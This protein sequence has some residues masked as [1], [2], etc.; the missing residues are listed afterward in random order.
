MSTL[1]ITIGE[2]IDGILERWG[3]ILNSALKGGGVTPYFGVGF[4]TMAQFGAA[5]TPKRWELVE[6]L[7]TTGPLTMDALAKRLH[8]HHRNV[9]KDVTALMEW[10]VIEKDEDDKLFVPWDEIAVR[11]P[12]LKQ[13][14]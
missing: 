3:G 6:E 14:A 12:L 5:F 8:R 1:E 7:K 13:A 4:T 9:H 2:P 11:W 10:L